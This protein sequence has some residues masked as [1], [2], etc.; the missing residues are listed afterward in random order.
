MPD[1]E[2]VALAGYVVAVV[3]ALVIT[4]TK[5]RVSWPGWLVPAAIVIPFAAL[6]GFAIARE[7]LFAFWPVQTD[8][9]W[10][11]QVWL[12]LVIS[13]TAAFLFLQNRARAV[14]MK[15]EVWVLVVVFTGSIGLLLMLARMLHLERRQ[16]V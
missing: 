5:Q 7:G 2:L 3:T 11:T 13:V 9:L 1:L 8:S 10:G 14:G 12:N 6:T 4:Q 16:E 15:S